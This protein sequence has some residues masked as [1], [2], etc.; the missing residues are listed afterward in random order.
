MFKKREPDHTPNPW[1]TK[2]AQ[3]V[4][5]NKWIEISH[6]EVIT[7]T[8]TDG[9]YGKVHY[10]NVAIGIIPMDKEGNTWIVGQYRYTLNQY[11]WEIVEGGGPLD[12][13]ILDA[14]KRELLEE[15]GLTAKV[16]TPLLEMHLSNSVSDEYGVA[17]LAT[18]LEMGTAQPEDTELLEVRKH[19]FEDVYQMAMRGEITDALS[20]AAIFK[21]KLL[22]F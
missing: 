22:Y 12:E 21:A 4:Y 10:K 7:P 16:W 2:S 6:R 19:P 11:H 13:P 15:T 9:I 3:T 18:D 17:F 5:E 14:A 1:Q 8:G 20:L